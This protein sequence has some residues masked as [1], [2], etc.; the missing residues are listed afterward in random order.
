MGEPTDID[1][2]CKRCPEDAGV[3]RILGV[4]DQRQE[5]L[6]MQ[7]VRVPGGRITP[8][9]LGALARIAAG[10]TPGFPLHLTT[11]Q[12][13]EL[14]GIPSG[15]LPV[16]QGQV[17]AAGLTGLMACGDT[18]R[19]LTVCPG[20]G[21]CAGTRDLASL[22][23]AMGAA[24]TALPWI[25]QMPRKFKISLSGC[26]KGC[27]R[28][29]INDLGLVARR[30]GAFT[31]VLAGSLGARPGTGVQLYETLKVDEIVPLMLGALEL[32]NAEGDRKTRSRARL[33]HVRERV[34]EECFAEMFESSFREQLR[35]AGRRTLTVPS[36]GPLAETDFSVTRLSPPLGDIEPSTALDLS[37]AVER[38]DAILR[39]GL[40]HDLFVHS[41]KPLGLPSSLESVAEEPRVVSCPGST[42]CSRGL[43][44]SRA[45]ARKIHDGGAGGDLSICISG[46]PNNCS[47]AAVADIGFTGRLATVG[48]QR[49]EY[50]SVLA[51]GG[52]GANAD[53]AV[54]L[55]P[56]VPA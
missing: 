16:V 7:R 37:A 3:A 55:H 36:L 48:G 5:G 52:K 31:A 47:H 27:A 6:L 50:F 38:A 11:R 4:Y 32:F 20:C 35:P 2:P 14:H 9:Q 33:R 1:F 51:G 23:E 40:E 19:N 25:R 15:K 21:L 8:A 12:D 28:P 49:G 42:W 29:W 18:L 54:E 13:I 39:I 53:L 10:E 24:A 22:A 44:D 34:G 45:A 26:E 30:D 17:H 41:R 43:V 56:R 46:C